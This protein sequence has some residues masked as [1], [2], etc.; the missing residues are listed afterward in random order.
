M[1]HLLKSSL[2]AMTAITAT[3]MPGTLAAKPKP[4]RPNIIVIIADDL[5]YGDTG[6]YGSPI[7]KTP[8]IDA[9][10]RDGIRFTQAYS[11]HPVCSP[12]RAALMAGR[13]QTRFGYE[14]NPAGRDR[15]KGVSRKERL[16]PQLLQDRGYETAMIGK[17]HLGQP[18]GYH[19]LDRGFQSYFGLLGGATSF[20]TRY[21]PG[22]GSYMPPGAGLSFGQAEGITINTGTSEEQAMTQL[23]QAS[24]ILRDRQEA[25]VADYLTDAFTT[26]AVDLIGQK[27]DRPLFLYLAHPAPHTP[28]QATRKYMDRYAHI[29]DPG[30]RV[31]AA[32][33]SALDDSIGA[34]RAKLVDTGQADNT[35][36][37]FTSDNGCAR[38]VLGACSN[39]P[40][41]GFKRDHL[42]GGIRIPFIAV[43]PGRIPRGIV[44]DQVVSNLDILPTAVTGAQGQVPASAEGVDL[45]RLMARAARQPVPRTLY[46]RA[47]PNFAI[48]DGNWKL[49]I[50]NRYDPST[51][52]MT[53]TT[54]VPDGTQ[55]TISALGQHIMLYDLASDPGE[56]RN[57][58]AANPQVVARL[59]AKLA[60]WDR[61]NVSAQWTSMRQTSMRYDNQELMVYP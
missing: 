9:L 59:R 5:G 25:E 20:L 24:P 55:A 4:P 50:A 29:T 28:L 16:L 12:S 10:A 8:N 14:F 26:A 51:P 33:V 37:I 61:G 45:V 32:M 38:Y 30:K 57:V 18:T 7:V 39:A 1:R 46:W 56:K 6:T 3:A 11:T 49:W 27:R 13:A 40:L 17:W 60:Q 53:E 34:I 48:R 36:I 15:V 54:L 52:T 23:R 41:S 42:E 47:G 58:A 2:L 31:Y 22:D 21:G 44:S 19:P 43:W 35:L